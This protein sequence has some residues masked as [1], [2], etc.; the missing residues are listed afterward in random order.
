MS[1]GEYQLDIYYIT[2]KDDA[3]KTAILS[4]LQGRT[5][6]VDKT[7]ANEYHI[8]AYGNSTMDDII[9]P[10]MRYLYK[11]GMISHFEW[12]EKFCMNTAS[13]SDDDYEAEC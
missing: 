10:I 9:Q 2:D 4:V 8:V 7:D 3:V 6:E 11:Q 13:D 5:A 1:D 12:Y